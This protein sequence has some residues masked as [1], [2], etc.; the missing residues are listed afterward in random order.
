[1]GGGLR[2]A[3]LLPVGVRG[4]VIMA[5][6]LCKV[7]VRSLLRLDEMEAGLPI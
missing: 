1:M 5:A 4:T 3:V 2:F 6:S 7:R